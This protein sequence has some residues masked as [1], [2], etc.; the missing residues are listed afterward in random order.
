MRLGGISSDVA[1]SRRDLKVIFSVQDLLRSSA[2]TTGNALVISRSIRP[3]AD[4]STSA[5]ACRLVT[6]EAAITHPLSRMSIRVRSGDEQM[7]AAI[8]VQIKH[9]TVVY[10]TT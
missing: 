4:M 10:Q 1:A 2:T 5:C 3:I 8:L 6:Q 9:N 7:M